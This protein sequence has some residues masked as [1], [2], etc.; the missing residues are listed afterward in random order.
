[1]TRDVIKHIVG[2]DFDRRWRGQAKARNGA[3]VIRIDRRWARYWAR[4]L[5]RLHGRIVRELSIAQAVDSYHAQERFAVTHRRAHN[6]LSTHT[7]S[8]E[9]GCCCSR[10][11]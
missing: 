3:F 10:E 5:E 8:G 9:N 4:P 11:H 2:L 6:V 1:M 7:V